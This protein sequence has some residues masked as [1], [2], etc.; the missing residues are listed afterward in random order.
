MYKQKQTRVVFS[1]DNNEIMPSVL[2]WGHGLKEENICWWETISCEKNENCIECNKRANFKDKIVDIFFKIKYENP[3]D[4][5][6]KLDN[7]IVKLDGKECNILDY[8]CYRSLQIGQWCYDNISVIKL[9][10]NIF[11]K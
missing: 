2:G 6:G 4:Y 11:I 9:P 8:K 10:Y 3:D 7:G 5:F 1:F